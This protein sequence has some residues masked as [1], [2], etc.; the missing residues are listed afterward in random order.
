MPLTFPANPAV[1][2][3]TTTGGRLWRW[4]GQAWTVSGP[5]FAPIASVLVVGGGSGG[6]TG[7]STRPGPG[8][9]GGGVV[10]GS[11]G[12][13]FGVAYTLAVGAGG[14]AG[15]TSSVGSLS[16]FGPL[17]AAGGGAAGTG[18]ANLVP[19]L[20]TGGGSP[21]LTRRSSLISVQGFAGGLGNS[22]ATQSGGGGGAGGQGNDWASGQAGGGGI[23]VLSSIPEVARY[24]GA[25]GGAG[26]NV[27]SGQEAS[28]GVGGTDGGGSGGTAG[29]TAG[30]AGEA[31]TGAG[32]GGG[33]A[34][35][36]TPRTAGNGGSGIVVLRLPSL[37]GFTVSAG[38]TYSNT[39][40]GA[41][42]V[43][44]FTA[45]TGTLILS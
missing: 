31:N 24:F 25:G 21:S 15:A 29:T 26:G 9:G 40:V 4:N 7:L 28:P 45:G 39:I 35:A 12:V 32:G 37:I 10:A 30:G 8:G 19:Q 33:G 1:N 36:S 43:L 34:G 42:R 20:A 16:R 3:T 41:E 14:S 38:L 13:E 27:N 17:V 44:S 23:G 5:V 6:A 22:G 11:V 2:D 18:D